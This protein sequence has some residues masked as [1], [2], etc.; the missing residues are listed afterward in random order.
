VATFL[1]TPEVIDMDRNVWDAETPNG[2]TNLIKRKPVVELCIYFLKD[3]AKDKDKAHADVVRASE[4]W[5]Q[6][7]IIVQ[8]IHW[9]ELSPFQPSEPLDLNSSDLAAQISCNNMPDEVRN[10]LFNIG[11]PHFTGDI[12]KSIAVYYIPGRRMID[13]STGCHQ[14]RYSTSVDTLP[15]HIILLTDEA[16]GRALAHE[17]GHALFTRSIV[18]GTWINDDPDPKMDPK[19]NIHNTNLQNLM[20]VPTPDLP[21][22]SA[23]QSEQAKNCHLVLHDQDLVYGFTDNQPFKLKVLMQKLHVAWTDDEWLSDDALESTWTFYVQTGKT[24]SSA[25]DNFKVTTTNSRE[26]ENSRL[27]GGGDNE[28]V[29]YGLTDKDGLL[30]FSVQI[31][32]LSDDEL[33]IVVTGEDW[34]SWPNPN[35][36]LPTLRK[37]WKKDDFLWGSGSSTRSDGHPPSGIKGEHIEG[38]NENGEIGYWLFYQ[39]SLESQ[40][41][42]HKFRQIC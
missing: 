5:C 35:D 4:I 33:R 28:G 38:P 15:E 13:G 26:Y 24:D 34:D 36:H 8:V 40:P 27:H 18:A 29:D 42:T 10:Q 20:H 19:N 7:G 31:P 9:E 16:D 1:V 3:S 12:H 41:V 23:V 37:T 32:P 22:I 25:P 2:F 14:L 17:L 30:N 39:I 11:R 21:V 6:S